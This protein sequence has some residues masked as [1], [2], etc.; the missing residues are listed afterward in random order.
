M[1]SYNRTT[2]ALLPTGTKLNPAKAES[3]MFFDARCS[4]LLVEQVV[5]TYPER[6]VR[7]VIISGWGDLAAYPKVGATI[8][9]HHDQRMSY[10]GDFVVFAK[11]AGEAIDALGS[12]SL[13][14]YVYK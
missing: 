7:R 11:V 2:T 4:Y 5:A 8:R 13:P 12:K 10:L 1:K 3:N 14:L 9:A 6:K